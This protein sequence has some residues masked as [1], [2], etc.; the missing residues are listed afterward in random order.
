[1]SG[2]EWRRFDGS[3]F[4][5]WWGGVKFDPCTLKLTPRHDAFGLSW[6]FLKY[7]LDFA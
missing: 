7:G 2:L 1:M 4:S 5:V 3:V 6:R